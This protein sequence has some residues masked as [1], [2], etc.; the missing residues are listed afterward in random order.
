MYAHIL[1]CGFNQ[2]LHY[3]VFPLFCDLS[4]SEI[5]K[6][7]LT[8][9]RNVLHHAAPHLR[10]CFCQTVSPFF[11]PLQNEYPL[12]FHLNTHSHLDVKRSLRVAGRQITC[13]AEA[14]SW[15]TSLNISIIS[16]KTG[17]N[18]SYALAHLTLR[19][20]LLPSSF[21]EPQNWTRTNL[22]RLF[23]L[24]M[25][26]FIWGWCCLIFET[27]HLSSGCLSLF[28]S[29]R[30]SVWSSHWKHQGGEWDESGFKW[31]GHSA[32]LHLL[33]LRGVLG[34]YCDRPSKNVLFILL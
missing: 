6:D 15:Q 25:M 34:S 14:I 9:S 29:D 11:H 27:F 33:F 7:D 18:T 2:R 22:S 23:L 20:S 24:Q 19:P 13:W 1:Y 8:G 4:W 12:P 30:I 5:S 10:S 32:S 17:D 26:A 31:G 3:N 21:N 16:W 28:F